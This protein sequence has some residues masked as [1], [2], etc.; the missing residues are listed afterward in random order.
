MKRKVI[1]DKCGKP[2]IEVGCGYDG[3]RSY[4]IYG[5]ESCDFIEKEIEVPEEELRDY[6]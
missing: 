6:F 5:C 4:L 2:M 1:C 3:K